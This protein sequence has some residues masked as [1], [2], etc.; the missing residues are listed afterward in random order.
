MVFEEKNAS[1]C[2]ILLSLIQNE[3][4]F[5]LSVGIQGDRRPVM[6]EKRLALT[7]GTLLL[8]A[9]KASVKDKSGGRWSE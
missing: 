2:S 7:I 6:G 4:P 3:P 8:Q 1:I 9:R 5:L